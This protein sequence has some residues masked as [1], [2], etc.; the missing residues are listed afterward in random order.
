MSYCNTTEDMIAYIAKCG[1]E[2]T[3]DIFIV[4]SNVYIRALETKQ[5]VIQHPGGLVTHKTTTNNVYLAWCYK[6]HHKRTIDFDT[7]M[8]QFNFFRYVRDHHDDYRD[9]I[10]DAIFD[11][12]LFTLAIQS[13]HLF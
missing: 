7:F 12:N 13:E 2:Y 9:K 3:T 8:T 1:Y 11:N 5:H 10:T 4:E 6:T